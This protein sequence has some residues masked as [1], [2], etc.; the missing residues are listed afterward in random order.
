MNHNST[1]QSSRNAGN[2][3]EDT[4][5]LSLETGEVECAIMASFPA[6]D[7]DYIA[8]LP[9]SPIEGIEEG[10]VLL[11]SYTKHGDDINLGEI[12]DDEEFEIAADAF[13]ELLD[14]EAF[15]EM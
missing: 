12:T 8:L 11:Y 15:D 6:G 13:D 7:K 14:E 4:I 2:E 1:S 3:P 10:E 5:T 9:L